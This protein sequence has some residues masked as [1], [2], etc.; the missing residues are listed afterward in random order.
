MR[1]FWL[2]ARAEDR[3]TPVGIGPRRKGGLMT[4]TIRQKSKGESV[5]AFKIRCFEI[6]DDKLVT[7]VLDAEDKPIGIFESDR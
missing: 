2:E 1:D 3:K 7:M 6:G 5:V 4:A